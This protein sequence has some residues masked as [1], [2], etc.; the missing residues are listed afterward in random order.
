M[1]APS[2]ADL[3]ERLRGAVAVRHPGGPRDVGSLPGVR[4]R[5][6]LGG[7]GRLRGHGRVRGRGELV[8]RGRPGRALAVRRAGLRRRQVDAHGH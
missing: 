6:R 2:A 7:V 5:P 8:L 4:I 3:D 1:D